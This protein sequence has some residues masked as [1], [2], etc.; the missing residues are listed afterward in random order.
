MTDRAFELQFI[1][2]GDVQLIETR[3]TD[4]LTTTE[5]VT[6]R[7]KTAGAFRHAGTFQWTSAVRG[8]CI[9]LLKA[10]LM[11]VTGKSGTHG[12]ILGCQGS[13]AASLDYAMTKQPVW[14]LDMFGT[15]AHGKTLTHRL[16]VRTNSNRKRPGPVVLGLNEIALSSKSITFT[17][18]GT[19]VETPE[20][21]RTLLL[22]LSDTECVDISEEALKGFVDT[23]AA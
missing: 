5:R 16:I 1:G 13:L 4:R 10:K 19:K 20:V 9:L 21:L 17:W 6:V 2:S 12:H 18:N 11:Q 3:F 14:L 23:L 7:G 22:C 8:L 15:D